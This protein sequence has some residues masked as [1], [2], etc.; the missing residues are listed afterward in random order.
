M[1]KFAV[2]W[3]TGKLCPTQAPSLLDGQDKKKFPKRKKV[4]AKASGFLYHS[5]CAEVVELVDTLS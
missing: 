4:L 2:S 5:T 3:C 1:V